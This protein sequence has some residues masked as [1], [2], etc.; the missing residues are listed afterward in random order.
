MNTYSPAWCAC[1][2]YADI[3][4]LHLHFDCSWEVRLVVG[5]TSSVHALIGTEILREYTQSQ[6]SSVVL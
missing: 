4:M 5:K 1:R 3:C 6:I 2:S